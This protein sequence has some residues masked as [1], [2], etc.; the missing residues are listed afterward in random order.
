MEPAAVDHKWYA[1]GVG[2]VKEAEMMLVK[3]GVTK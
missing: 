2:Q 1:A 3:Y